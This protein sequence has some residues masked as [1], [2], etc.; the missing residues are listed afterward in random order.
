[1]A[2]KQNNEVAGEFMT[3]FHTAIVETIDRLVLGDRR[4]LS[5]DDIFACILSVLSNVASSAAHH[6]GLDARRFAAGMY[7]SFVAW[8][9]SQKTKDA[10]ARV[11]NKE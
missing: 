2:T 7:A 10:L 9:A 3:D 6:Y 5:E 11:M 4:G 1:M 8:E